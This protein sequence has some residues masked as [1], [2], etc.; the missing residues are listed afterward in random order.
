MR[1]SMLWAS[2]AFVAL[3]PKRSTNVCRRAISLACSAAFLASRSSSSARGVAV[4]AVRAL[5]LDEV[6]DGVLGRA[7]EVQ[8]AGDRLVEQVEVVAD[9]EQRAAVARRNPISHSLASMS[10]WLVGSSRQQHVAAGEQDA[11]QLDAPPLAARQHADRQVDAVVAEPEP[12]RDRPRL[13]LG[14]VAAVD[15]ERL[16]GARCSGRR[17][18]RRAAPPSRCAASRCGSSSSSMPRPDSTW[19]TA[20][21]PSSTPAMRGSCGR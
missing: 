12:G 8:H 9:D 21:R 2:A 15:A 18:A 4:L 5:V 11:G 6:A 7:V 17:C 10:R 1:F 20:V 13:A 3:A 14:G 19:V 16:L